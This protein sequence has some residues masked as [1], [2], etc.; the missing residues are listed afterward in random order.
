MIPA[1]PVGVLPERD[2][3]VAPAR[4][5]GVLHPEPLG[6]VADDRERMATLR[7]RGMGH[8]SPGHRF[9]PTVV[10]ARRC[11][12]RTC[13]MDGRV[14]VGDARLHPIVGSENDVPGGAGPAQGQH[15]G[16]GGVARPVLLE[17]DTVVEET[18]ERA[19][20]AGAVVVLAG[21][22]IEPPGHFVEHAWTDRRDSRPVLAATLEVDDRRQTEAGTRPFLALVEDRHP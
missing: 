8:D 22:F 13:L 21:P 16:I 17:T 19:A 10:H 3:A 7:R 9:E 4:P 6:V 5:P 2:A 15:S 1:R 11:T 14:H 20:D 18:A 12:D